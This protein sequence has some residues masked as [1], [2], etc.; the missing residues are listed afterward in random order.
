MRVAIDAV[1]EQGVQLPSL[2]VELRWCRGAQTAQT[3]PMV[4]G[5]QPELFGYFAKS[6]LFGYGHG[7]KGATCG[8]GTRHQPGLGFSVL[9]VQTGD[10]QP[11]QSPPSGHRWHSQSDS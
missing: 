4:P 2:P 10:L 7:A 5:A 1:S 6:Q 3:G 8:G 11:V 9:D